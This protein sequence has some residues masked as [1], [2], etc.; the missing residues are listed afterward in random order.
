MASVT[1]AARQEQADPHEYFMRRSL[2]VGA[3][4]VEVAAGVRAQV[5]R[6]SMRLASCFPPVS[7]RLD[8]PGQTAR[9][10]TEGAAR[11]T[12]GHAPAHV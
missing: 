5:S 12:H 6:K 10:N 2:R 1:T 9:N 4:S 8:K 11:H 7:A 3:E